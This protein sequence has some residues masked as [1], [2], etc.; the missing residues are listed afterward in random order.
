MGTTMWRAACGLWIGAG[1][2]ALA[3][4]G[5]E[6]P[7]QNAPAP[8]TGPARFAKGTTRI[9]LRVSPLPGSS[10]DATRIQQACEILRDR[11]RAA[12][13]PVA[14]ARPLGTDR[15]E[16]T[17]SQAE[18]ASN[19]LEWL[20][21][22]G[23]VE[24]RWLPTVRSPRDRNRPI[25]LTNDTGEVDAGPAYL[26]ED[27]DGDEVSA[28]RVLRDSKLLFTPHDFAATCE[29]VHDEQNYT[30]DITF[31]LEPEAARKFAEFTTKYTGDLVAVVV[32]GKIVA[33]PRFNAPVTDGRATFRVHLNFPG[34]SYALGA[35]FDSRPLPVQVSYQPEPVGRRVE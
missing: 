14:E 13:F 9:E 25:R 29:K 8:P 33:M 35:L 21:A 31:Q 6:V 1:A 27:A 26:F 20:L 7:A 15:I 4:C 24:F 19:L 10:V 18:R 22:V 28:T 23:K 32:D 30:A 12:A 5:Q 34:E 16:L 11:F 17:I 2:L 3:G